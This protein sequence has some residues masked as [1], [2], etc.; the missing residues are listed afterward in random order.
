MFS[1]NFTWCLKSDVTWCQK[2]THIAASWCFFFSWLSCRLY[3]SSASFS[4]RSWGE[5]YK[6]CSHLHLEY[7]PSPLCLWWYLF[8]AE[9]VL[10]FVQIFSVLLLSNI[11]AFFCLQNKKGEAIKLHFNILT[12]LDLPPLPHV[13]EFLLQLVIF[14]PHPPQSI[15]DHVHVIDLHRTKH[16]TH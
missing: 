13:K 11:H 5:M 10:H 3:R 6:T 14:L 1:F 8:S 7:N 15:L 4:R 2:Y 12:Q 16:K 9:L